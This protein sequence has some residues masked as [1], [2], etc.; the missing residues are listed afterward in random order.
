MYDI[1]INCFDT[2]GGK[3]ICGGGLSQYQRGSG[4][5]LELVSYLLEKNYL[6]EP[7]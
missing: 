4:V 2:K 6:E 1:S 3:N 7:G 5:D